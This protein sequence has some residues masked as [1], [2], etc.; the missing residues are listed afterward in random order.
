MKAQTKEPPEFLTVPE[1][2]KLIRCSP[3]KVYELVAQKLIPV[4]KPKGTRQLVFERAAV[5]AWLKG[6]GAGGSN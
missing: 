3:S 1:V 4:C 5:V 6:E 2:A